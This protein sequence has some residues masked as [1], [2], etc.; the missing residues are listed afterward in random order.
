M[1]AIR[2]TSSIAVLNAVES[3]SCGNSAMCVNHLSLH[4]V[5]RFPEVDECRGKKVS[6]KSATR[7]GRV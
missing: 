2:D 7:I 6:S 1:P 3:H 5:S 4:R